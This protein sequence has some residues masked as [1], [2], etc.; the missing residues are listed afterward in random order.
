MRLVRRIRAQRVPGH[1]LSQ[2]AALGTVVRHGP[3]SPGDLAAHE[4][5][6]PPSMTRVI[7]KLEEEGLVERQPH[8]TDRRQQL[9]SV[10]EAGLDLIET[11]RHRRDVWL[12]QRFAELTP[13]DVEALARALPVLE[14]LAQE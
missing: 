12:A 10:T 13:G 5:V 11:D 3:I 8:P 6:Q 14:R 4:R 2:L 1:T 7:S 9:I